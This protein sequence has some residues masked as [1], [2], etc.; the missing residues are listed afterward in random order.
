[1]YGARNMRVI[2]LT[3]YKRKHSKYVV[4]SLADFEPWLA[5]ELMSKGIVKAYNG[6]WPPRKKTKINLKD[7]KTNGKDDW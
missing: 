4:G 1:M 5:N 6:Q 3:A 7:L 2:F